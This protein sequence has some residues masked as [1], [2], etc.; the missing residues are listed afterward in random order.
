MNNYRPISLLNTIYKIL[1]V[2]I[3]TR[4]ERGMETHL[5][6][7]QY[8]FRKHRGT[9]EAIHC[10]RRIIE[11][12][13]QTGSKTILLLLDWEKAFD[14]ISH[15]A[16]EKTLRRMNVPEELAVRI[17]KIYNAPIFKTEV[18][19]IQ[20]KWYPQ[21]TGI[22]QGCPLSPYLFLIVMTAMFHDVE[23][24]ASRRKHEKRVLNTNFDEILYADDTI[25]VSTDTREINERLAAIEK[26]G[27]R[28]GLKLNKD[29]C[30]T[31]THANA[32]VRFA[33]G[34]K[35][36]RREEVKYLGCVLNMRADTSSEV[37][38]RISTCMAIMH[39]MDLFWRKAE[40]PIRWKVLVFD[41]VIRSKLLYGLETAML[42]D[43]AQRKLNV[44]QLKGLR[45][46]LRMKTTFV[47]RANTNERVLMKANETLENEGSKRQVKVFSEAYKVSRTKRCARLLMQRPSD[48]TRFTTLQAD[49]HIWNFPNKRAGR[50]KDKWLAFGMSDLW[51]MA[52]RTNSAFQRSS[53]AFNTNKT[54]CPDNQRIISNLEQLEILRPG[55]LMKIA[56]A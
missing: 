27:R 8:G 43:S 51:S 4:L 21:K 47:E 44:F 53:L 38:A 25:C 29:K 17:M 32:N 2:I 9:A 34:T 40:C 36:Q 35:V 7:T 52:K 39:K 12:A 33:D 5:Q 23:T 28:Y 30:E 26:H 49:N 16:L 10:I 48:P 13:E 19:G 11:Q 22:R 6:K 45:K 20:S 24:E 56:T 1:A 18:E 46:I 37:K 31:M 14:K 54:Y 50:P 41:A 3:K 42:T 15:Q 55:E